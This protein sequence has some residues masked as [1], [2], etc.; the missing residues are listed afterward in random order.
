M[1]EGAPGHRFRS[2]EQFR[3]VVR[4]PIA[5]FLANA[6]RMNPFNLSADEYTLVKGDEHARIRRQELEWTGSFKD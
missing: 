3:F 2:F 5:I 1:T 4:T 6:Y